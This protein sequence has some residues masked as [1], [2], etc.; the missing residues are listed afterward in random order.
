MGKSFLISALIILMGWQ[1]GLEGYSVHTWQGQGIDH[2]GNWSVD[3]NWDYGEPG[4]GSAV[5]LNQGMATITEE[6]ETVH[7]NI[8]MGEYSTEEGKLEI[9]SG[10]LSGGYTEFIGYRGRGT[11]Y[12]YGGVH[13]ASMG[14]EL[15]YN[16]A[17]VG[18]YELYDGTFIGAVYVGFE[19]SGTFRQY[20]GLVQGIIRISF[21]T[22]STGV[23]EIDDGILEAE[24]LT[25]GCYAPGTFRITSS[26]PTITVLG[27]LTLTSYA[28]LEAA[29][30]SAI[31]VRGE[32]SDFINQKTVES[33]ISDLRHVDLAFARKATDT[34]TRWQEFEVSCEDKGEAMEGYCDNFIL[35]GLTV[36]GDQIGRVKLVDAVD[37]GNRNGSG[38]TAEALY[39]EKLVVKAGSSLDLSNMHLYYR[40]AEIA[41]TILNGKPQRIWDLDADG[42]GIAGMAE[43]L[44]LV[45]HWLEEGCTC[46]DRCGGADVNVDGVVDMYDYL[47][48]QDS[49]MQGNGGRFYYEPL[50][51]APGW[52]M[53]GQWAFG[54]PTGGGGLVYGYP[55]PTSGYTGTNVY[56]V[57]LDGDYSTA[58]TG[59]YRYLETTALDCRGRFGVELTFWQRLN[60]DT[61]TYVPT[62]LSVYNGTYWYVIWGNTSGAVTDS[63]WVACSYDVSAY[64]DNNPN[65]KIRW[66]YWVKSGAH[67]Y[68]GW[69]I[70][71]IALWDHP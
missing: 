27:D 36:G 25:V 37:N 57:N 68:S 30:G 52:S 24:F 14:M 69:N 7:Y 34:G 19:G 49:W 18:T 42:D 11:I 47:M 63:E 44:L 50:D 22:G 61:V 29:A 3:T 40:E 58:T 32:E 55:D 16:S 23:Y 33:D 54:T 17:A 21:K 39:V 62:A 43:L 67:P 20:G 1:A 2:T 12:Q 10:S 64:A 60:T 6:G 66:G 51:T 70:D 56:G 35:G 31:E 5:K 53:T 41:G 8:Y 4:V 45:S 9:L 26:R 46:A 65:F 15:A 28:I 48:L 13:R 71:D 38:G 59:S